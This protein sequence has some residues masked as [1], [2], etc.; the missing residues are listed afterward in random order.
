MVSFRRTMLD[1]R[2]ERLT[3]HEWA[4]RGVA[5]IHIIGSAFLW[6]QVLTTRGDIEATAQLTLLP[7]PCTA[8]QGNT[9]AQHAPVS[10]NS[11]PVS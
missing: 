3:G 10:I 6:H 11:A 2:I 8:L 7:R 5:A 9:D 4:G 1:F